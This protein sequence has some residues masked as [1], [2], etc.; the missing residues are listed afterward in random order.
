[1]WR[2]WLLGF[3]MLCLLAWAAMGLIFYLAAK[4]NNEDMERHRAFEDLFYLPNDLRVR[5]QM[6]QHAARESNRVDV[7]PIT[8]D[9]IDYTVERQMF[10]DGFG[11]RL[12]ATR[13]SGEAIWKQDF[14]RAYWKQGIDKRAQTAFVVDLY[15]V[16]NNV[17]VRLENAEPLFFDV[18]T[19]EKR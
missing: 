18:Q 7:L 10:A 6:E 12:W 11:Y 9:S 19:G 1:M 4:S 13:P 8:R 16:E 2:Y 5:P 14:F 3:V 17:G 15:F